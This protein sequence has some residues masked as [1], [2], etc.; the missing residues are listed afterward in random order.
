VKT[1]TPVIETQSFCLSG[2]V[3]IRLRRCAG[4]GSASASAS[5]TGSVIRLT[6]KK[7]NTLETKPPDAAPA[8]ITSA[9][10]I[11]RVS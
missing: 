7:W 5:R 10:K 3:R 6:W 8:T 11:V 1:V 4:F 2:V 9:E